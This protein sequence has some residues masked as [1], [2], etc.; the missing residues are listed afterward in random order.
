MVEFN[1]TL[2]HYQEVLHTLTITLGNINNFLYTIPYVIMST[3]IS[4]YL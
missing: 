2:T 4:A 1:Y 3:Y